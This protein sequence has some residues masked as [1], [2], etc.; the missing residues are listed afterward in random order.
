MSGANYATREP[1]AELS[2][3]QDLSQLAYVLWLTRGI[4]SEQAL[5]AAWVLDGRQPDES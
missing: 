3:G 2:N 5:F 4:D 1:A